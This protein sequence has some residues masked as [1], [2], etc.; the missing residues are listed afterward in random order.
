MTRPRLSACL[1]LLAAS[2]PSWATTP[3]D[4][5]REGATTRE[6]FDLL[7]E[8]IRF[9]QGRLEGMQAQFEQVKESRLLAETETARGSLWYRKPDRVRW[10][11][12]EPDQMT[13]VVTD[14][15]MQ[16]WHVDLK[17]AERMEI[18]RYSEQVFR[19]M[20]A[21]AA[22][23]SLTEYFTVEASFPSDPTEPYR[24]GLTP[25]YRRIAKR[26][27]S[28]TIW[29]DPTRFLPVRLEYEEPDGDRT[30][31]RL[32]SIEANPEL[33]D[34]LFELTLPDDVTVRTV[35]LGKR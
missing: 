9:E 14:D 32:S 25:R 22:L 33:P 34:S 7:L 18:G 5:R 27:A 31:Y 12:R 19:M 8:R 28:M 4:P 20:G 2:A 10:E 6:R 35:D 24:L 15:T 26:I 13:I 3:P 21:T 29:I 23:D 16:T 1:L 30:E 17:R 11:Y